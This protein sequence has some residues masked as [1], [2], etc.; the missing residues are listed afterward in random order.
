M[1]SIDIEQQTTPVTTDEGDHERF[2]HIV[3]PPSEV[4]RAM[5]TGSPCVA[6]CGKAWVPSRNP[7]RFPVCQTCIEVA[8]SMGWNTSGLR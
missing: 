1:T 2:A 7:D 4:T 5:V 3:T 6:L 8:R